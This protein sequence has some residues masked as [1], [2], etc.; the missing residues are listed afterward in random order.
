MATYNGHFEDSSGNV[1]LPISGG[2]AAAIETGSTASQAYMKGTYLFYNNRLCKATAAISSGA[3]LSIGSNISYVSLGAE[4]KDHL[5]ASNGVAFTLQDYIN[6][7][8]S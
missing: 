2:I 3:S 1:L 7:A 6:G 5:V 8:Y 4:I